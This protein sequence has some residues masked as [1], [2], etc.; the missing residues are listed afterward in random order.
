MRITQRGER[1]TVVDDFLDDEELAE[2]RGVA[3]R[4]AFSDAVNST[5]SVI[6]AEDGAARRGRRTVVRGATDGRT[7]GDPAAYARIL[8][9]VADEPATFGVPGED[10]DKTGFTFWNYP[11]GSRLGWHSDAGG[12]RQGS[13]IL[14]L[15]TEWRASW[16]GETLLLDEDASKPRDGLDPADVAGWV[17][18]SDRVPVA[19]LPRPNRLLYLRAGTPHQVNR[20]D[21]TAGLV[22]TS[23]TGHVWK[24]LPE[25]VT[26]SRASFRRLLGAL[27]GSAAPEAGRGTS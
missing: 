19:V 17:R 24:K 26:E 9:L 16:G 13:Y 18:D 12:G 20:V 4:S 5:V 7:A 1:F 10:W 6:Q 2:L 14:F 25:S 11:A 23:L 8:R 21:P 22:R 27:D 3:E 15:H